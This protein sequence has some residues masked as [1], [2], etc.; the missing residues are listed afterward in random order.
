MPRR[1]LAGSTPEEAE[2]ETT[3]HLLETASEVFRELGFAATTTAEIARRARASKQSLYARFPSKERLFLAALR[4]ELR[5]AT[6]DVPGLLRSDK[7]T[8]DVLTAIS[9]RHLSILLTPRHVSFLRIVYMEAHRFP[10]MAQ[11]FLHFGP[12]KGRTLLAEYIQ[13]QARRGFLRVADARVAAE[14]LL[15]LVVGDA[16]HR[17][18]LG[19][20]VVADSDSLAK[21]VESAMDV[22][23]GAY[24]PANGEG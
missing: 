13:E 6:E 5:H 20:K 1:K 16:M 9:L 10:D 15:S 18:L 7:P 12:E 17:A 19:L 14:H 3:E 4:R 21:R 23:F 24:D 2:R 22:F 11:E 8:R